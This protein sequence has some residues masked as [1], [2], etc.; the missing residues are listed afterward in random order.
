MVESNNTNGMADLKS[1]NNQAYTFLLI[2]AVKEL[3]QKNKRTAKAN[4]SIT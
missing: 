3:Q 1:V 2:N 4:R